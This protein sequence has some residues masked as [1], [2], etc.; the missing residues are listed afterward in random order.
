[1]WRQKC[2]VLL[3]VELPYLEDTAGQRFV[4]IRKLYNG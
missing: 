3:Q 2:C 1:M 4:D